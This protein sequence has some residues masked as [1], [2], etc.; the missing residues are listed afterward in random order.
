MHNNSST[1]L[2]TD[3]D[4]QW[5]PTEH[6]DT[7]SSKPILSDVDRWKTLPTA[8]PEPFRPSSSASVSMALLPS[9]S[10]SLMLGR[11]ATMTTKT[12]PSRPMRIS[13]KLPVAKRLRAAALVCGSSTESPTTNGMLANTL[14]AEILCKP[15]TRMSFCC[16]F[17]SGALPLRCTPVAHRSLFYRIIIF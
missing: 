1:L 6:L 8:R 11:S 16:S 10:I 7:N 12:F 4:C 15:S 9:I 2:L 13:S 14:P 3:D 5:I 17:I